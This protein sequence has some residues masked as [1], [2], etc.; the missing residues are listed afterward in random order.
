M[1]IEMRNDP[2]SRPVTR[3]SEPMGLAGILT[4]YAALAAI[5]LFFV[6]LLVAG[7]RHAATPKQTHALL[8]D[9]FGVEELVDLLATGPAVPP[10]DLFVLPKPRPVTRAQLDL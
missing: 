5:L 6:V 3:N 7:H 10:A 1:E 2:S 8:G 9:Y 4:G